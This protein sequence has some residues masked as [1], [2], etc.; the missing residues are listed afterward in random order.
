MPRG[1]SEP[2]KVLKLKHSLYG[3]KQSP[4][5]FFQHLKGKLEG[6]GFESAMDVDPCLFISDKVICLVYVDDTL[7]CSPKKE[8]ILN[9]VKKLEDS[10]MDLKTKDNVARFLGVHMERNEMKGTIKL[11][12]KGLIK[13]II[14]TLEIDHLY[15]KD[16]PAAA[17]PL[18]MDE[19]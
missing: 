18:V 5:N 17:E 3:L 15:G 9:V 12:Q 11:T 2:S 4:R 13:W 14:K 16:T 8:Y 19:Y 7:F 10:G 6:I 1:F